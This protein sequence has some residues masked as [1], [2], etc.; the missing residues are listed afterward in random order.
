VKT[1][2]ERDPALRASRWPILGGLVLLLLVGA[3]VAM[4]W[5]PEPHD[6]A[7]D[8][9]T[10]A[11]AEMVWLEGGTFV[12]GNDHP[13]P[14]GADESPAHEVTVNGF[15]IEKTEVTNGRFAAFVKATGYKTIAERKPEA[16]RYPGATAADLVPGSAVYVAAD[17]STDPNEWANPFG[18]PPW[19]KYTPG[20]SWKHPDGPGSSIKGKANYPVVHI[21]WDDAVAYCKWTGTRLPTEAEWEYAARGGLKQQEYC[22]GTAKQGDGGKWFANTFQGRFPAEDTGADGF[23][24]VAPVASFPP[25]GYGLHDMS[26]NVW[27]WCHDYYDSEYYARSPKVNPQGP[28]VGETQLG[29]MLRVRRGGSFLCADGYCRRY[30]PGARDKNPADSGASHTGFRCVK[31]K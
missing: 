6:E 12:M 14:E 25:N 20:A 4:S 30:L 11:P 27:E 21:A 19:W 2:P 22:W 23:A 28:D 24:G 29:Q 7:L 17:C 1:P 5:H 10:D 18:G 8:E 3:L 16:S 15:F 26:G 9:A 13:G 31:D